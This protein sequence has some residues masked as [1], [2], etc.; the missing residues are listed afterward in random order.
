M[1][2]KVEVQSIVMPIW[3]VSVALAIFPGHLT[4]QGTRVPPSQISD[5]FPEKGALRA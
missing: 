1:R 4:M 5:F 3:L 2:R